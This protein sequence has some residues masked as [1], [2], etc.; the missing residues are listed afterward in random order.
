[1]ALVNHHVKSPLALKLVADF[2]SSLPNTHHICFFLDLP[3]DCE[4]SEHI[5]H[6][7]VSI[8]VFQLKPPRL[9]SILGLQRNICSSTPLNTFSIC[10]S[11]SVT[12]GDD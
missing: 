10:L 4:P 2:F 11:S 6:G 7:L 12:V 1:V 5:S 8:Q 9:I 3:N